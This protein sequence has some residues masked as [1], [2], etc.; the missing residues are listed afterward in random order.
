[1][2]DAPLNITT[3]PDSNDAATVLVLD[4][5][6]VIAHLFQFQTR[7]REHTTPK[8]V[9]DLSGVPYMDSS[10]LGAILNSHVSAQKNGRALLLAGVNERVHALLQLTK[11]DAILKIYPDVATAVAA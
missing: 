11:V 5:P 4:G 1:M 2:P 9:L 6:I 8:I 7:L 10:G 3:S